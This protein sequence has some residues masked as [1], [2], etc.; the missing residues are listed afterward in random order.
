M[1]TLECVSG[2]VNWQNDGL[3]P[4]RKPL[5]LTKEILCV[6]QKVHDSN[7]SSVCD[8]E[9]TEILNLEVHSRNFLNQV[10]YMLVPA[11]RWELHFPKD[12]KN[13]SCTHSLLDLIHQ[14]SGVVN[15]EPAENLHQLLVLLPKL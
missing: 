15:K 1:R 11:P 9:E 13:R 2:I 3:G 8:A 14:N 12:G 4:Q 7:V 10:S 5:P 6:F